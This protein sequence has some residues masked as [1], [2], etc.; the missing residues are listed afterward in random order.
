[1]VDGTT[2]CEIVLQ[3]SQNLPANLQPLENLP[4][5]LPALQARSICPNAEIPPPLSLRIQ[6]LAER[7]VV[8]G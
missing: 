8:K 4:G 1:M 7:R 5:N 2:L 6:N 3:T